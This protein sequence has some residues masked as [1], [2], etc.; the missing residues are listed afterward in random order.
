MYIPCTWNTDH[1]ASGERVYFTQVR[2]RDTLL[3]LKLVSM[4][5]KMNIKPPKQELR[6]ETELFSCTGLYTII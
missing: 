5:L 4:L 1:K 3:R 2:S 6:F